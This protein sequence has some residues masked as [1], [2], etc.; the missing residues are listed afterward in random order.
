MYSYKNFLDFKYIQI[1]I[2][3]MEKAET[4]TVTPKTAKMP[5]ASRPK[6]D[7]KVYYVCVYNTGSCINPVFGAPVVNIVPDPEDEPPV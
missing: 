5:R 4:R 3:S 6:K 2:Y 7:D 1:E